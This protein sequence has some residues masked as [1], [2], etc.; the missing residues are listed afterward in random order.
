MVS[1]NDD[2][3]RTVMHRPE[4]IET[5]EEMERQCGNNVEVSF[6]DKILSHKGHRRYFRAITIFEFAALQTNSNIAIP[7]QFRD[8]SDRC[9]QLFPRLARTIAALCNVYHPF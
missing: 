5:Q 4:N 3:G 1:S 8:I 7:G 9:G 6:S 2:F